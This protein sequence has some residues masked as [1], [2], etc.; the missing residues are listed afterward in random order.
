[1][2]CFYGM[3]LGIKR[4]GHA[5]NGAVQEAAANLQLASQLGDILLALE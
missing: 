2:H 4:Q 3:Q 5:K 1:M